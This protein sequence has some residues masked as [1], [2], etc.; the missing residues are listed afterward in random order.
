MSPAAIS[1]HQTKLYL[2]APYASI[3]WEGQ[4]QWVVAE[5]KAYRRGSAKHGS[6]G[7]PL[8]SS[9]KGLAESRQFQTLDEAKAWLAQ[10]GTPR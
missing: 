1:G 9:P 3:R 2:D 8:G 4:G 6:P 5:W 7:L 10:T